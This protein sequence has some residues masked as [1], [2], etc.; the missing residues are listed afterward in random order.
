M[1]EMRLTKNVSRIVERFTKLIEA[2]AKVPEGERRIASRRQQA[3]YQKWSV[4]SSNVS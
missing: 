3:T 2:R 4:A 1:E